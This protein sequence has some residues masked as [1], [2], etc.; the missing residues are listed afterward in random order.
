MRL[1]FD[2]ERRDVYGRLLAYVYVG[3]EF[4]NAE[5]VRARLRAHAD[6]RAQRPLRR[7]LR[8]PRSSE[9]AS[10]GRG[11][12]EECSAAL[13]HQPGEGLEHD[14]GDHDHGQGERDQQDAEADGAALLGRLDVARARASGGALA[15]L[16]AAPALD[17]G[18]LFE[19]ELE[20]VEALAHAQFRHL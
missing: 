14:H 17:R 3:D 20:L 4:V 13:G 9:A 15:K 1:V 16:G 12:W 6:D 5:L 11:L 7:A 10:A 19:F 8:P 2:A 18:L